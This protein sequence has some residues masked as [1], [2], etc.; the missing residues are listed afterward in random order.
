M[1]VRPV[2][3]TLDVTKTKLAGEATPASSFLTGHGKAPA[4]GL[5]ADGCRFIVPQTAFEWRFPMERCKPSRIHLRMEELE[6]RL[7]PAQ[8]VPIA[9]PDDVLGDYAQVCRV[10][11]AR[12]HSHD[13]P[14]HLEDSGKA[15]FNLDG[16]VSANASGTA[17]HLGAFTLHD[18]ST[19]RTEVTSEGII[20]HLDGKAVLEAA[21]GDKLCASLSGSVN[22]TTGK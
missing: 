1:N 8:L 13:R 4:L 19:V 16:T 6:N 9:V 18:R 10:E 7:T 2:G 12:S 5:R 15:E 11:S 21:N 14:F 17:T 22:L 3:L 20:L